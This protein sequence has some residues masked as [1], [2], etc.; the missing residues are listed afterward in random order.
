MSVTK[1]AL[2]HVL[3]PLLRSSL[4]PRVCPDH[5]STSGAPQGSQEHGSG[6][7]QAPNWPRI[8]STTFHCQAERWTPI[9][10]EGK[11]FPV[12]AVTRNLQHL[13]CTPGRMGKH[14]QQVCPQGPRSC[15]L[16]P[17]AARKLRSAPGLAP[18]PRPQIPTLKGGPPTPA[19]SLGEPV[20]RLLCICRHGSQAVPEVQVL[21]R[22]I[23]KRQS[24]E[25]QKW[26]KGPF[27]GREALEL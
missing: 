2:P 17:G 15:E 21:L 5:L 16:T 7:C 13:S 24:S 27:P 25:M 20:R 26:R 23:I 19:S 14:G 12:W 1:T 6:S 4:P 8:M 9:Q 10:E 18:G 11:N 22:S 3:G